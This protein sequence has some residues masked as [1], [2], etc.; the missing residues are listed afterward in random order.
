VEVIVKATSRGEQDKNTEDMEKVT[1]EER[2]KMPS[3][4]QISW[5]I[6]RDCSCTVEDFTKHEAW[7]VSNIVTTFSKKVANG[8]MS[9]ICTGIMKPEQWLMKEVLSNRMDTENSRDSAS[10]SFL[11]FSFFDF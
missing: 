3:S 11:S 2:K 4:A 1:R 7:Q 8:R 6:Q 9:G 10:L 5:N